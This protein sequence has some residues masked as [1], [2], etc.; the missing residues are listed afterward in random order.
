MT[1][2]DWRGETTASDPALGTPGTECLT[3]RYTNHRSGS[4][5]IMTLVWG[6]PGPVSVHTPPVCYKGA[7]YEME[8]P[9]SKKVIQEGDFAC[10]AEFCSADFRKVG[11]A[12]TTPLR[13]LWAW[14]AGAGWQVAENP[15]LAFASRSLLFK[16]Y[17]VRPLDALNDHSD[18]EPS[19][20]FLRTLLPELDRVLFRTN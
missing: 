9:P 7:G 6:R 13:V 20:N 10:G 14:N 19:A 1:L 5:V 2:G 17:V 8:P 16:L 12:S 11:H 3:R 4:V 15:R 18:D